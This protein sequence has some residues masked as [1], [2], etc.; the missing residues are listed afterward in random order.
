MDKKQLAGRIWRS[1][2]NLR[3]RIEA[4]EYKD[5]ILGFIFYKF[6]SDREV[7]FAHR[8]GLTDD[9]IIEGDQGNRVTKLVDDSDNPVNF[10]LS[11][12]TFASEMLAGNPALA[13]VSVEAFRKIFDVIKQIASEPMVTASVA[14]TPFRSIYP[15]P[16]A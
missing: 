10:A 9:D 4:N 7:E 14:N 5:Y 2:K 16:N 12:N 3:S 13:N 11:K 1:A 8:E 15:T 6:L